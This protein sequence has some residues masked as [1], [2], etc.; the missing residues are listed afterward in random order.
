MP[1]LLISAASEKGFASEDHLF[2]CALIPP[3][4]SDVGHCSY[5]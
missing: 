4:D 2:S 1:L 3:S 5:T